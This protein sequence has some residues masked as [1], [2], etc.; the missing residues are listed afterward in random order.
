MSLK[1]GR[2]VWVGDTHFGIELGIE[3]LFLVRSKKGK[4]GVPVLELYLL[5]VF[6]VIVNKQ[7]KSEP[8]QNTGY[9]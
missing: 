9:T 1:I 8:I 7:F 6:N 3:E 5:Y 2:D 4:K